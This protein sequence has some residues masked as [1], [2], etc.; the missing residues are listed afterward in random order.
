MAETRKFYAVWRESGGSTPNKRHPEEQEA[1]AE[2]QRLAQQSGDRYFVLE[3]IG[4]VAP[5]IHPTQYTSFKE[6]QNVQ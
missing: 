2:A 6:K 4:I 5:V 1:I 3:T